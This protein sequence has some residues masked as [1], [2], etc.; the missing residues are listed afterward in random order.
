MKGYK[1]ATKKK[2]VKERNKFVFIMDASG[3]MNGL[4][5]NVIELLNAQLD[6]LK[7]EFY[8]SDMQT[9]VSIITFDYAHNIN[10]VYQDVPIAKAR[11]V[12]R[13]DY[14]VNGMTA[15]FDALGMGINDFLGHEDFNDENV[16]FTVVAYTDGD[17]ND[18]DKYRKGTGKIERLI[19]QA[20]KTRRFT[21]TLQ[22]PRGKKQSTAAYGIPTD[23]IREWDATKEGTREASVA[24]SKAITSYFN[25]RS[26]GHKSVESFYVE[27]DLSK[28]KT[29]QV[30]RE[31]D[32]LS[33]DYGIFVAKSEGQIRDFV[34]EKTKET[35]SKGCAYYQLMKRELVQADKEILIYDKSKLALYGGDEARSLVGLPVGAD[36]KVTPKDH[37][38]FEIFVQSTSVNRK[39]MVGQKVAVKVT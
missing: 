13:S 33:S 9:D 35:Y 28:L 8:R 34:E 23:N 31:L 6:T 17:E 32:D 2:V 12:T 22:V 7:K 5:G 3:S 1:M 37:A 27:T 26:L 21:I 15:L 30:K 20:Q 14:K 25:S 18:S 38:N 16:S 10:Y 29:S 4:E 24:T 19:N 11:K 39:L 36:A